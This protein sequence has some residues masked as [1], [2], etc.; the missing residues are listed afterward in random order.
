MKHHNSAL[1]FVYAVFLL[2]LLW[3]DK[4]TEDR[5]LIMMDSTGDG[6]TSDIIMSQLQ[7]SLLLK[8]YSM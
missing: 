8:S 1:Y 2:I 5:R 3:K 4:D 7:V 6:K